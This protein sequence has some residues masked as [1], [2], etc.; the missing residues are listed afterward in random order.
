[1]A[2]SKTSPFRGRAAKKSTLKRDYVV[3]VTNVRTGTQEDVNMPDGLWGMSGSLWP[4]FTI[5]IIGFAFMGLSFIAHTLKLMTLFWV[6][7]VASAVLVFGT[8][9]YRTVRSR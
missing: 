1:M 6:F 4:T 3:R 2:N 5:Y 7:L 8:I 9:V